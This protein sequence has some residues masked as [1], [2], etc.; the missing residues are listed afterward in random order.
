MLWIT[1]SFMMDKSQCLFTA[2]TQAEITEMLT[3]QGL[4]EISDATQSEQ[5][6]YLLVERARLLDELEEHNSNNSNSNNNS[7]TA[8]PHNADGRSSETELKQILEQ[9]RFFTFP[10]SLFT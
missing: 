9:V 2:D 6:A 1:F 7:T 5:I 10:I 4:A 3:Q 8:S